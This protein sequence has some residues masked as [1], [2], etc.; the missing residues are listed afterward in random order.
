MNYTGLTGREAEERL[1]KYGPNKIKE[2]KPGLSKKILKWIRSPISLMLLAAAIL[3]FVDKEFFDGYFILF[4]MLINFFIGYWQERKVDRAIEELNK[5]L[6]V[7]VRVLRD[8]VWQWV[9]SS[10]LVPE[11]VTELSLGDVIPADLKIQEAKNLTVNEASLTGESFP[12]EKKAGDVAYSGSFITTGKCVAVVQAT[13][14]NTYFGKIL[15]SVEKETGRSLLEKDI[16]S[17][18]RFLIVLSLGAAVILAAY[19]IYKEYPLVETITLT[20][21]LVIA[22][23]PIALPTVMSLIV[24]LGTL[25]LAKKNVVVRRLASLDNL[26]SVS[27][28]LS[29]KTGT[30]TKNVIMVHKVICC[31]V[32]EKDVVFYAFLSSKTDDRSPI[33]QAIVA[34]AEELGVTSLSHEI[35]DFTP[36]DSE[37][38][39]SSALVE[40]DGKRVMISVGAP[41]VIENLCALDADAKRRFENDV[42]VAAQGGYRSLA[43]AI[44]SVEAA[45]ENMTLV[46]ILYLSDILHED[47]KEVVAFLHTNGVGVRMLTGDNRAIAGRVAGELGLRED[48][49]FS[50]ILP[51]DKLDL[52]RQAKTDHIVAV[53][54]DGVNDLPALKTADV[55]IAVQNAVDALK[56]AADIV[57]LSPGLSVIKDAVIESRKI[58]SRIYTYSVYRIAESLTL[59]VT[60]FILG[61]AYQNYPL[62]P[63]QLILIVILNDVPIISLAFNRV[64]A[65]HN[66]AKIN[67][68]Q[69]FIL[70]SIYGSIEVVNSILLFLIMTKWL[71]LDWDSI[72]TIFFLSL[73]ISGYALIYV[74]HTEDWWFKF[75]PSRPVILATGLTLLVA[76]ALA[77]TGVFMYRIPFHWA[78]AVWL[79]ALFWM[80]MI[81]LAKHLYQELAI[82]KLERK[83]TRLE[84]MKVKPAPLREKDEAML[85]RAG[86]KLERLRVENPEKAAFFEEWLEKMEE[87]IAARAL[88]RESKA[89]EALGKFERKLAVLEK[90]TRKSEIKNLQKM[91]GRLR[92]RFEA[93]KVKTEAKLA[94]HRKKDEA[95]LARAGKKLERLRAENPEKA[96]YFE[97][98]LKKVE[99]QIA[100]RASARESKAEEELGKF[101][102]KLVALGGEARKLHE[103]KEVC[104]I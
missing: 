57:L 95:I 102:R 78:I 11:D 34:K 67:I 17:I 47:T 99:A 83:R 42:E 51:A 60:V 40:I 104:T 21:S 13:G 85:A 43:V 56:S 93:A 63:V 62:T 38:K 50:E 3:S 28:L 52:V 41:Q 98:R 49:I 45:E 36:A 6:A 15:F 84:E 96:A 59:V 54:G 74:V 22:G 55:G 100:A 92:T 7:K 26:A 5:Q 61:I 8:N 87:Q 25:T 14:Q 10:L 9:E 68:K 76:T 12:K 48:E 79:W 33:N 30:L 39:R 29:D 71:H 32:D 44:N 65:A 101:E 86:E 58:S 37:R 88:A 1:K 69:R 72:K 46:G 35:I 16:L 18:S 23:I 20:L 91:S 82:G 66:P 77:L 80:Q 75:L 103:E 4:L 19:F 90:T 94:S 27:L 97:K 53:T 81:E 70:S 31:G 2:K 64:R 73:T 24:S 89:E